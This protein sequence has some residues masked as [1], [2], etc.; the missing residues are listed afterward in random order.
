MGNAVFPTLTGLMYPVQKSP[1]FS[2]VIKQSVSGREVRRANYASALYNFALQFE[3]LR[4]TYTYNEFKTLLNFFK[5]RQG[6]FDSF[7]FSD[8]DDNYVANEL[9]GTGDGVTTLFQL[10][11]TYGGVDEPVSNINASS[12]IIAPVMWAADGTTP[13]WT[14]DTTLMWS[15][16]LVSTSFTISATGLI[17]FATA[18]GV[19]VPILWAGNF[20]YRCRFSDTTSGN[21]D[22]MDFSKFMNQLWEL[23]SCNLLGSL[24]TKI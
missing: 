5:A 9:I 15:T 8:P 2:T 1:I 4:D 13:M 21:G 6:S 24:G 14:T 23:K 3:F 17:T 22:Q 12:I 16:A 18:P 20:Y 7:L 19:S 10:T 11:R